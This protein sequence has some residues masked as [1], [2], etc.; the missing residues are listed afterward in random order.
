MVL[1]GRGGRP[2][3]GTGA[4]HVMALGPVFV[5]AAKELREPMQDGGEF[6]DHLFFVSL[7]NRMVDVRFTW[8]DAC[9]EPIVQKRM[10]R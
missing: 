5:F 6:P 8:L 3:L 7:R 9:C 10:H 2:G 1:M 4:A